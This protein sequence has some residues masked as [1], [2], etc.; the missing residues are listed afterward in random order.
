MASASSAADKSRHQS[1]CGV[2][3][4]GGEGFSTL[5]FL[6]KC[7]VEGCLCTSIY[8]YFFAWLLFTIFQKILHIIGAA[9]YLF[10]S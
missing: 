10:S 2:E 7:L 6:L 4:R 3:L 8:S 5:V 1:L 9:K